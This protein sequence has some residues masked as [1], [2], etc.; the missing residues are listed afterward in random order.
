[1]LHLGVTKA[2]LP[3]KGPAPLTC[4]T[5][6][7]F[8]LAVLGGAQGAAALW[9]ANQPIEHGGVMKSGKSG[10]LEECLLLDPVLFAKVPCYLPSLAGGGGVPLKSLCWE[11]SPCLN[12]HYTFNPKNQVTPA[13][14]QWQ[15]PVLMIAPAP[16]GY[17]SLDV[18]YHGLL[19]WTCPPRLGE[20]PRTCQHTQK[21]VWSQL[22]F[23]FSPFDSTYE[24]RYSL[25]SVIAMLCLLVIQRHRF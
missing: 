19:A 7:L 15:Y 21:A 13:Q 18:L 12:G 3:K 22:G 14:I 25:S 5:W 23:S 16:L 17:V 4:V 1:M 20:I 24:T 8:L 9:K 6:Q 11:P 10:S 2:K